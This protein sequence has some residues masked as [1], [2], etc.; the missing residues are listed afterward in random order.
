MANQRPTAPSSTGVLQSSGN[1]ADIHV[2]SLSPSRSADDLIDG[3]GT[4]RNSTSCK[5]RTPRKRSSGHKPLSTAPCCDV[6]HCVSTRVRRDN[7]NN[8]RDVS[9][10]SSRKPSVAISLAV[11]LW[12]LLGVISI[13][14]S[15]VLL[16]AKNIP[17][18]VL[19]VQQLII[20]VAFLRILLRTQTDEK[21]KDR[22]PWRGLQLVPMRFR[23]TKGDNSDLTKTLCP[24]KGEARILARPSGGPKLPKNEG[25]VATMSAL[26]RTTNTPLIKNDLFLAAIYFGFG[27]LL[28]NYGFQSGSAAFVET[29]KAAEP[30][31]SASV[32]GNIPL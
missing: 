16:S 9:G 26:I 21:D 19:T 20:G 8:W 27:F 5:F 22:L 3:G 18:L 17:P 10:N 12:Y 15:K 29:V 7:R 31:T 1:D 4:A 28:T 30:I 25:T 32:A 23:G 13:S 6:D 2:L 24:E 11:F 14:S